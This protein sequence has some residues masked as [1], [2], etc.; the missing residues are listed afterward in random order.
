MEAPK[1]RAGRDEVLALTSQKGPSQKTRLR[2]IGLIVE[3]VIVAFNL[4][5]AKTSVCPLVGFIQTSLVLSNGEAGLITTLPLILLGLLS[6]QPPKFKTGYKG[7]T[8][9]GRVIVHDTNQRDPDVCTYEQLDHTLA[10]VQLIPT[11]DGGI[12][13]GSPFRSRSAS[14]SRNFCASSSTET[15]RLSRALGQ[16]G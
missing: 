14:M 10:T 5:P 12:S 15:S 6:L 9:S 3:I 2:T 8:S 16:V 1:I 13:T 7:L 11:V 4:R